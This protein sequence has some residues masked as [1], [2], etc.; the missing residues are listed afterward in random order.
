MDGSSSDAW[1]EISRECSSKSGT[2]PKVD[3]MPMS[4]ASPP[5]SS[6]VRNDVTLTARPRC[7]GKN[8]CHENCQDGQTIFHAQQV[9]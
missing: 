5:Q 8:G 1:C 3:K 7:L 6:Q 9:R 2:G 4:T